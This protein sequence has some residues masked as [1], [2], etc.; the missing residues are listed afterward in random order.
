[1][2]ALRASCYAGVAAVILTLAARAPCYAQETPPSPAPSEAAST[3]PSPTPSP[4]ESPFYSEPDD[5][6]SRTSDGTAYYYFQG[7]RDGTAKVKQELRFGTTLWNDSAQFRIR[8]PY[9]TK[10]PLQ[11]NPYASIGDIEAG[12][13]YNVTSKTFDHSLE[14][15]IALPTAQNGVDNT[16]TELK[17]FYT[18][19]WKLNGFNIGYT[20]EYDQSILT[21]PGSTYTSYYEGKLTLPDYAFKSLPGLKFSAFY[22][23]RVI[24]QGPPGVQFKDALGGY[25]FGNLGDLALSVTDSWGL[26]N[27]PTALWKYKFE[28]NAT[29]KLQL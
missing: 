13:N 20:N 26:G 1:M 12:Y 24:F 9:I 6:F 27:S 4:S 21:P 29:Y 28:A 2:K 23:Y 22:N 25:L 16:D 18:I 5:I 17:A 10:F 3:T 14:F 15:R 11:G 8:L 7:N 19:K